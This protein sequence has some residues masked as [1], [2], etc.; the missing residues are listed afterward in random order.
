M[1]VSSFPEYSRQSIGSQEEGKEQ[2]ETGSWGAWRDA[3]RPDG[4]R[5]GYR[6]TD[7]QADKHGARWDASRR[8]GRGEGRC[9]SNTVRAWRTSWLRALAWGRR[10]SVTWSSNPS[11]RSWTRWM[12]RSGTGYRTQ[13]TSLTRYA[14][15]PE[16]GRVASDTTSR[17]GSRARSAQKLLM[18]HPRRI[19]G[20]RSGILTLDEERVTAVVRQLDEKVLAFTEQLAEA[21]KKLKAREDDCDFLRAAG[22]RL[23]ARTGQLE[24]RL[25]TEIEQSERR[26]RGLREGKISDEIRGAQKAPK[27]NG[28]GIRETPGVQHEGVAKFDQLPNMVQ[29]IWDHVSANGVALRRAP[30]PKPHVGRWGQW[31]LFYAFPTARGRAACEATM[32]RWRSSVPTA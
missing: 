31:A 16:P 23:Q 19:R 14:I 21:A 25:D 32:R 2:R 8:D 28:C 17:S 27:P 30:R 15:R 20:P 24:A 18:R 6:Q 29:G 13:G 26:A 4:Y 7:K 10:T 3:S 1:L 9:L 12:L 22:S 5:C 11:V